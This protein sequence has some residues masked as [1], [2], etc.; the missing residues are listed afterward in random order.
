[1]CIRDS[2]YASLTSSEKQVL[3]RKVFGIVLQSSYLL[4][5]LTCRQNLELS[6]T[7]SGTDLIRIDELIENLLD[8]DDELRNRLHDYPSNL[9][10][11]QRQRVA[12]IRAFVADP[13]ILFADEP[14]A[15][16]DERNER[17]VLEYCQ[18]WVRDD[19][20]NRIAIFV[21]HNSVV[22]EAADISYDLSTQR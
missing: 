8:P 15:S 3:R 12:L 20:F 16:L 6:C 14:T 5:N 17:L 2:D 22:V 9:S 10:V 7:I 4:K 19:S 13:I 21:S 18:N 1:M 11:G